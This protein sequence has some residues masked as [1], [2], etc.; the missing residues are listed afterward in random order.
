MKE[1]TQR[2]PKRATYTL[3][4]AAA[5]LGISR[6]AAYQAARRGEIPTLRFGKR[7]LV[8]QKALERLLDGTNTAAPAP[9]PQAQRKS[10]AP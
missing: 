5:I 9:R 4:V 8:P 1:D 2:N 6:A 10:A 7:I 3:D